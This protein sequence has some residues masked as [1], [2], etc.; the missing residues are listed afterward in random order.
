MRYNSL[1]LP[2]ETALLRQLAHLV[3]EDVL[4]QG[5]VLRLLSESDFVGGIL[6]R[7]QHTLAGGFHSGGELVAMCLLCT[8]YGR[9]ALAVADGVL[10]ITAVGK[11]HGRV[12]A[13]LAADVLD[14][15]LISNFSHSGF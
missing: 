12:L 8:A 1:A 14:R 11:A 13:N 9:A 7:I 3:V 4:V 5:L 15:V 6:L 10:G 2:A